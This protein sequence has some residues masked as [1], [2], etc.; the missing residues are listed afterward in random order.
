MAEDESYLDEVVEESTVLFA[1]SDAVL[2]IADPKMHPMGVSIS[3]FLLFICLFGFL[4]GVDFASPDD[5][6]VRPDEFVYQ[7]AQTAPEASATS[8]SYTHLT[9][10]TILRV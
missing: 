9:L 10:P 2:T 8:V 6:L 5:G 1:S 7:L 3:I 4:N